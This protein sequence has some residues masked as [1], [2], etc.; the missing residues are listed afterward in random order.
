MFVESRPAIFFC[1]DWHSYGQQQGESRCHIHTKPLNFSVLLVICSDV[2]CLGCSIVLVESLTFDLLTVESLMVRV[3]IELLTA[4]LESLMIAALN[5]LKLNCLW[6][7][8]IV[9]HLSLCDPCLF[10]PP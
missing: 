4:V 5:R 7:N 6:S 9:L 2:H 1:T 3:S 10:Q 8:H